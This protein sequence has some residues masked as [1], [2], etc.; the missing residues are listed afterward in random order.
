MLLA[1]E[2]RCF[3]FIVVPVQYDASLSEANSLLIGLPDAVSAAIIRHQHRASAAGDTR[4][5]A[6][7]PDRASD[8]YF[9]PGQEHY[10]GRR[11]SPDQ[12][13]RLWESC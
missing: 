3:P 4:F 5:T 9:G 7:D 11:R 8:A 12:E 10:R 2:S 1:S 13:W 6:H